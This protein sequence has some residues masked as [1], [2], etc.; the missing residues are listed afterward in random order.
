MTNASEMASLASYRVSG[1]GALSA[2]P[3]SS[4]S[5]TGS[6]QSTSP[7]RLG[8]GVLARGAAAAGGWRRPARCAF[9]HRLVATRYS[10][11]RTEDRP[12]NPARPRHALSIVSC[13]ASSASCIEPSIR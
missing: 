5:G 7:S 4:E 11:V 10:Q 13:S 1:P 3:A 12:S 6:S 8:S 2:S 9:R